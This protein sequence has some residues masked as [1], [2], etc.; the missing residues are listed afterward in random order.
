[1]GCTPALP[2]PPVL[3]TVKP[4]NDWGTIMDACIPNTLTPWTPPYTMEEGVSACVAFSPWVII[5]ELADE[6]TLTGAFRRY[7]TC[8]P[9]CT[10]I[11]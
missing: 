3:M 8:G 7:V 5:G 4:R 1:M 2:A 9:T 6:R 11:A 10:F